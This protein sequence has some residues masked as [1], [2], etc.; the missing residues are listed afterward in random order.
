MATAKKI[1]LGA[2]RR[3]WALGLDGATLDLVRPWADQA[4]L[5]ILGRLMRTGGFGPL[6][7]TYPPLTGPAWSSF[8]TGMSPG[9]HGVLEFFRPHNHRFYE[10]LGKDLGWDGWRG[11]AWEDSSD[12]L[13]GAVEGSS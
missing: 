12:S 2:E 9:R 1:C 8:M 4:Q 10:I 11:D 7:S 5:P 3:I 13:R 6:R